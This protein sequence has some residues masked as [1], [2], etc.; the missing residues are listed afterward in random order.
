MTLELENRHRVWSE[1]A[2]ELRE[3]TPHTTPRSPKRGKEPLTASV[4][5]EQGHNVPISNWSGLAHPFKRYRGRIRLRRS[6]LVVVDG[7]ARVGCCLKED[8]LL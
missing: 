8:F 3:T 1:R 7:F 6:P 5:D 4:C 2:Q